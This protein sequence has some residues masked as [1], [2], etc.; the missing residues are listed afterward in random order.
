MAQNPIT[1]SGGAL[2]TPGD[3]KKNNMQSIKT[4][5]QNTLEPLK[6]KTI[7]IF[8]LGREGFSTYQFLSK[9]AV[10]EKLILVDD[11]S[12]IELSSEWN[13]AKDDPKVSFTTSGEFQ[14]YLD[15]E[16]LIF[17][18]PGIPPKHHFLRAA[19]KT[20]AQ[21]TSSTQLFFDII[22][23]HN[24][25]Y[26]H[27]CATIAVTGTKGKSTT[28]SA[29]YHVLKTTG[30]EVCLGGNIGIPPLELLNLANFADRKNDQPTYF[31][32][33]LSAH[34]LANAAIRPSIAVL[35]NITPEHMDYYQDFDE[36]VAAKTKITFQQ[37]DEDFLIFNPKYAVVSSI[38]QKTNAK[39]VTFGGKT[40]DFP[41]PDVFVSENQLN[42]SPHQV[43]AELDDLPVRGAHTIE[44][45]MPAVCVANLIQTPVEQIRK[46]LKT[47]KPLAHR[48]E[49]VY[50]TSDKI[51][52]IDDSLATTPEAAIFALTSFKDKPIILLA[53]GFDRH[54]NFDNLAKKILE[55]SVEKL[56]LFPTT[57]H[58][59]EEAVNNHKKHSG[60][61]KNIEIVHIANMQEAVA[62]AMT[63]AKTGSVVLLSPASASFGMFKDY[64]D[65]SEQFEFEAKKY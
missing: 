13:L 30:Q 44:N 17:V 63:G 58:K 64:Q 50:Q 33:E 39:L 16:H 22:T 14:N 1:T 23:S 57:G 55:T 27:S 29:I 52:F 65:R 5:I 48:L 19:R 25:L 35:L 34:Q 62:A 40:G 56:I 38:A 9:W 21:L 32:M 45:L 12:A 31:V 46:G 60:D 54:Q 42:L 20:Q 26:P 3:T 49:Q 59:I 47:F 36:Y 61:Q 10:G 28:S 37:T 15:K 43:V 51:V 11:R 41:Y 7:V 24:H 53:G 6:P 4:A 18:T 2:A 8:G